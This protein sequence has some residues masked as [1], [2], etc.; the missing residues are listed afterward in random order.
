M[1]LGIN[2][3]TDEAWDYS[4]ESG[5]R[6]SGDLAPMASQAARFMDKLGDAFLSG[7]LPTLPTFAKMPLTDVQES[8]TT[9]EREGSEIN[10]VTLRG[11]RTTSPRLIRERHVFQVEKGTNRLI[12]A[13]RYVRAEG[14]EEQLVQTVEQFTY[15]VPV[16]ADLAPENAVRKPATVNIQESDKFLSLVMSE[17][18]K[19]VW[20]TDAPR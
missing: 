1:A 12:G 16:P 4:A 20:R 9:E 3:N 6:R 13:Q 2:L 15:N 19:E 14:S 8:V 17:D 18:G 10:V 11:V 5:V 7:A